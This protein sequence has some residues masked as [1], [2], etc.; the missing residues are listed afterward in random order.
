MFATLFG[1]NAYFFQGGGWN[2]NA[3]IAQVRAIVEGHTLAIND[4]LM[5]RRVRQR[6]LARAPIAPGI[7]W[8][9]VADRAST[10]DVAIAPATGLLYPNKPPGTMLVTL[11]SYAALFAVESALGA[12][13][14]EWFVLTLNSQVVTALS[15]GLAGAL[16]AVVLLGL[17][18]AL[19][20][21]LPLLAHAAAALTCG[22][23]TLVLPFSTV[24]FDQVL[25]AFWPLLAFAA[26]VAGPRGRPWYAWA[27]GLAAGL[28]VLTNYTD[29]GPAGLLLVYLLVARRHGDAGRYLAGLLPPALLLLAY[30]AACF[31]D[32][33]AVAN[34]FQ[35]SAFT[36]QGQVF[37]MLSWPA[38]SVL[39]RL[40]VS[41]ERGLLL[42]SPVLA[43]ASVGLVLAWRAGRRLEAAVAAAVFLWFW[44]LNASFN[45]WQAGWTIGPRYLIP[46]VPFLCLGLAPA[47][48]RLPRTTTAF[49][50]VSA[51]ILLL[52]TAVD[53][54]PPRRA[55]IPL[56][57]W[58]WPLL[59]GRTVSPYPDIAIKGPVS[60]NP[61]GVYE[62]FYF[63]VFPPDAA[64][65]RWNA[66]NLGEFLF[67]ESLLSLLP[68]ALWVGVGVAVTLRRA[69]QV[70]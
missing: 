65:N 38:P 34:T 69:R 29:A 53:V 9:K 23:G 55:R 41:A 48:A 19:F 61:I 44:L 54:Q 43:L 25:A 4:Y 12:D 40:L 50:A 8:E 13:P 56:V 37:G 60:V 10:A 36:S 11:P 63:R 49:A 7:A 15:V 17:S 21:D 3:R 20:P 26:L 6:R 22:L 45:S 70:A 39:W 16:L 42:T 18:R 32:P 66:H 35:Y 47:F 27:A 67:P 64:V 5:Y 31:G 58:I 1:V 57:D 33:L 14:D 30:Q 59:Q 46:A 62:G 28:G 52:A 68:L 2:Q 24:L 51:V